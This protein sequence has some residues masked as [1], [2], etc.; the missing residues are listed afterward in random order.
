MGDMFAQMKEELQ[1]HMKTQIQPMYKEFQELKQYVDESLQ[2]VKRTRKRQSST[3][4]D[5][6]YVKYIVTTET[7]EET[8]G[9][10][11]HG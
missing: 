6:P 3:G 5:E 1:Q 10:P 4:D 7:E 9:T 8:S 11:Q 2:G